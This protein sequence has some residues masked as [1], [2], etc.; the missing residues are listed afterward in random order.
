MYNYVFLLAWFLLICESISA[1]LNMPVKELL[2]S[3]AIPNY[4]L[5]H[6]DPSPPP[7]ATQPLCLLAPPPAESSLFLF[8]LLLLFSAD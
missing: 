1:T 3:H 5:L 8:K 7:L 4:K 6:T 2:Q